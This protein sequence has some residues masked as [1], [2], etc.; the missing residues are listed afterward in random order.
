MD[1]DRERDR[2]DD[3]V[4]EEVVVEEEIVVGDVPPADRSDI[5]EGVVPDATHEPQSTP[6]PDFARGQADDDLRLEGMVT[7]RFSRGQEEDPT[8]HEQVHEGDFARGQAERAGHP[9]TTL[10]GRFAR[11]QQSSDP[12]APNE[13]EDVDR[14]EPARR[15]R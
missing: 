2:D 11:G 1:H 3:V 6:R 9:E 8:L 5:L 10:D 13:P 7:D 12:G 15:D 14:D 4:V